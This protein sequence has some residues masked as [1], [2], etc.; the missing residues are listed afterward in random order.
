MKDPDCEL[1]VRL[2]SNLF[3][4]FLYFQIVEMLVHIDCAGCET[5][6]KKALRKLKGIYTYEEPHNH[7]DDL[8]NVYILIT[9]LKLILNRCI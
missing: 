1:H 3:G 9:N 7:H 5:K 6:I 8:N 2:R 4:F